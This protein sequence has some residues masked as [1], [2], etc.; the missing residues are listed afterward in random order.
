MANAINTLTGSVSL[1]I[2]Q[3]ISTKVQAL[4]DEQSFLDKVTP[5]TKKLLVFWFDES[6][7]QSRNINF[8]KGQKEAILNTIYLHEIL[9][10]E[11][12]KDIY[13]EFEKEAKAIAKSEISKIIGKDNEIKDKE[14]AK[15]SSY[16]STLELFAKVKDNQLT[17]EKYNFTKYAMKMATGTGKTWVM[18]ALCCGS[19]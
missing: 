5:T 11:N 2:A 19:T 9:K 13:N 15:E 1:Y 14:K 17:K 3:A 8:H 16:K 12:V 7:Q 18:N 4:W 10:I 6:F